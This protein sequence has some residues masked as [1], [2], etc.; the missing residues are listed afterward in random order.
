MRFRSKYLD[1]SFRGTLGT[2]SGSGSGPGPGSGP[3]DPDLR[4]VEG[5]G[6]W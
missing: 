1:P 4:E 5:E 6:N 2:R 3:V